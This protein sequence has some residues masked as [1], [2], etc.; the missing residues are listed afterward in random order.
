MNEA[1]RTDAQKDAMRR[2]TQ[3]QNEYGIVFLEKSLHKVRFEYAALKR[4]AAGLD[5]PDPSPTGES[6]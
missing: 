4:V 5:I 1:I 6:K 2:M 3:L